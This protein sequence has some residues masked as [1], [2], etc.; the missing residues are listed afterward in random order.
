VK[1]M[2]TTFEWDLGESTEDEQDFPVLLSNVY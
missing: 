1:E 2:D